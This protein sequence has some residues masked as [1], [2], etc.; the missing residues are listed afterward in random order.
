MGCGSVCARREF[1]TGPSYFAQDAGRPFEQG[2]GSTTTTT[3]ATPNQ[4]KHRCI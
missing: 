4:Q 2:A 3:M 1:R